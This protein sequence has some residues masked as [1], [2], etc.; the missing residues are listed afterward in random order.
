VIE[1]I[2]PAEGAWKRPVPDPDRASAEFWR[3]ASRGELLVQRC[4]S[5]GHRQHYPR[6]MCTECWGDV[7][8]LSCSGRG[9]VHT[10]S[11][12]RG[13][14][15]S[16]A[17][18]VAIIELEEGPRMMGNITDTDLETVHIGMAVEAYAVKVDEEI[19]VPQWRPA[20]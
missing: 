6:A 4:V 18:V 10:F 19:G 11:R 12:V 2:E 17:H 20:R 3:A 16:V 15:G 5:C 7:E 9:V 13:R 8:W 1:V 14:D